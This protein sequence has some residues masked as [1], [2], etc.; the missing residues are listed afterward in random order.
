MSSR[1]VFKRFKQAA[2]VAVSRDDIR[3]FLLGA[4]GIRS[5]GA[6]V[7]ARNESTT[8]PEKSAHAEARL[9]RRLNVGSVVYVVRVSRLDGSYTLARPC[10]NCM[11]V[12]QNRGVKTIYYSISPCEYGVIDL[13]RAGTR[14]A[15]KVVSH[16]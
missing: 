1:D 8:K 11:R 14:E 2:S 7:R 5:D 10:D 6:L 4:V 3:T 9:A 15:V 16:K 13:A 12:L